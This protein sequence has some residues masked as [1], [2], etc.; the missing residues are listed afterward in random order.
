MTRSRI[1]VADDSPNITAVL[2]DI[3]EANDYEVA[4]VGDGLALVAKARE[5]RPD[6][7]VADLMMPGAYGSVAVK[8]LQNEPGMRA[9]PVIFLTAMTEEAA[10]KLIPDS[11]RSRLMTKPVDALKLLGAIREMLD[12]APPPPPPPSGDLAGG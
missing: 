9:V 12:A 11:L 6:L 7:I 2:G 5:W 1:L 8:T 4:T 10:H 3:L